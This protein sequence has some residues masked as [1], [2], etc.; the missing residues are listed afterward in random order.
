MPTILN[1]IITFRDWLH[2]DASFSVLMYDLTRTVIPFVF[3][4]W[5][6]KWIYTI[7]VDMG[8]GGDR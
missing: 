7:L 1:E 5:V 2:A 4:F 8:N 3:Y 6:A